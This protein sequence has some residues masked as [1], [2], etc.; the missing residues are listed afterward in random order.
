MKK[1]FFEVE[2]KINGKNKIET[3]E[4]LFEAMSFYRGKKQ[5]G[6]S[7]LALIKVTKDR[8]GYS[9]EYLRIEG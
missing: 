7:F 4:S 8:R 1:M 2:S 5:D 9:N 3:F 6:A